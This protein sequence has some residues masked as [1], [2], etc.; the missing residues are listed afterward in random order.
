MA[1]TYVIISADEMRSLLKIEKGWRET[2]Q[3]NEMVFEY[4]LKNY[5]FI[6]IKVF[7]S[8]RKDNGFGRK[9]GADAIRCCAVDMRNDRGYIKAGRI[10]RTTNWR[11][12]L[13]ARILEVISDA[14]NRAHNENN[15]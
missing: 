14:E 3:N 9:I 2:T 15:R 11:D 10:N 6:K 12:N 1:A 13:K 4:T 7:S 5:P 8:I